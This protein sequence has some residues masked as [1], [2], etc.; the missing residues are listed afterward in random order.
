MKYS[1]LSM[2]KNSLSNWSSTIFQGRF[3]SP[4]VCRWQSSGFNFND[5]LASPI[6]IGVFNCVCDLFFW[7]FALYFWRLIQRRQIFRTGLLFQDYVCYFRL[8]IPVFLAPPSANRFASDLCKIEVSLTIIN[9]EPNPFY[10]PPRSGPSLAPVPEYFPK[11][12]P[13]TVL[14]WSNLQFSEL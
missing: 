14:L 4:F 3:S 1:I 5:C 12:R 13:K 9:T 2:I 7:L 10:Q 6:N 11:R 8:R